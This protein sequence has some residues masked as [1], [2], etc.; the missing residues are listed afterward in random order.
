[1]GNVAWAAAGASLGGAVVGSAVGGY[2]LGEEIAASAAEMEVDAASC[3]PT[4]A[5]IG[6]AYGAVLGGTVG[7]LGQDLIETHELIE[8]KRGKF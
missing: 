8:M 4:C 3:D 7:A 2:L 5:A 6:G 1:M